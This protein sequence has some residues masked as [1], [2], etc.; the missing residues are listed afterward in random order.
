[1]QNSF[2]SAE[3]AGLPFTIGSTHAVMTPLWTPGF[4]VLSAAA[5]ETTAANT[6]TTVTANSLRDGDFLILIP[7]EGFTGANH[8]LL[9]VAPS[10]VL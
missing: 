7:P 5:S 8:S 9:G 10:N 2:R 4:T 3:V 6:T 1:M